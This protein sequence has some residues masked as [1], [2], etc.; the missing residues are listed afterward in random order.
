MFEDYRIL[1]R[2][3]KDL[4]NSVFYDYYVPFSAY[5]YYY[6]FTSYS[7]PAEV[8]SYLQDDQCIELYDWVTEEGILIPLDKI[9]TK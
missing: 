8:A 4:N 1:F 6:C 7:Y 5:K 9:Y 2:S 3:S